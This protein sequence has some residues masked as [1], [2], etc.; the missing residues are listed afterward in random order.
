MAYS[1]G[2]C[3]AEQVER[4]ASNSAIKGSG[5]SGFLHDVRDSMG[6]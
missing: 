2:L 5:S 6:R 3:D 4:H 1:G